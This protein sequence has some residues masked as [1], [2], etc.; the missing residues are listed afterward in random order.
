MLTTTVLPELDLASLSDLAPQC[1]AQH[2][3]FTEYDYEP[4]ER[5]AEWA[6]MVGCSVCH[7]P[8]T[9]LLCTP[10]LQSMQMPHEWICSLCRDFGSDL[11]LIGEPIPL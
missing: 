8:R 1:D 2:P 5:R 11:Y 6:A 4:C 7:K 10:D 3:N 9:R